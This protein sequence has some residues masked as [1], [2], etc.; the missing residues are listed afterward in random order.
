MSWKNWNFIKPKGIPFQIG[1]QELIFYPVSVNT[2]FV[3][4]DLA[5]PIS[6]AIHSLFNYNSKS[7]QGYLDEQIHNKKTDETTIRNRM[8]PTPPALAKLRYEQQ[9]EAMQKALNVLFDPKNAVTI[10]RIIMDSLRDEFD[11]GLPESKKD[12]TAEGLMRELDL[13]QFKLF[14]QGLYEG[15]KKV[16]GPLANMIERSKEVVLAKL[17]QVKQAGQSEKEEPETTKTSG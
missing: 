16:F 5:F 4:R 9:Q 1:E 3:L 2:I 6:N 13:E 7:D 11:R 14:L 17:D 10:F 15:N 8:E 12:E